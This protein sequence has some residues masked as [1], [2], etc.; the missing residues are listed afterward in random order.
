MGGWGIMVSLLLFFAGKAIFS[1]FLP[2]PGMVMLGTAYLRI[3]AFCQLAMCLE[4]TASG[5][6]KGMGKTIPPSLV[7]ITTNLARPVLALLLSRTSLG[8][9]GVW[10]AV[11]ITANIR[12]LWIC[13]WYFR[14]GRIRT[15]P[16]S[17]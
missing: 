3:F 11:N 6:F 15:A 1:V 14:A 13:L 9:Y 16:G 8:I 12:G 10:I 5:A 4:G 17:R 7:S 2:E